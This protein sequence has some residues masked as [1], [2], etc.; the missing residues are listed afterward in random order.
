MSWAQWSD[1]EPITNESWIV[2]QVCMTL[3]CRHRQTVSY[4]ACVECNGIGRLLV[5][6]T[7]KEIQIP[8][9]CPKCPWYLFCIH[10]WVCKKNPKQHPVICCLLCPLQIRVG[11]RVSWWM[12]K[13]RRNK[14]YR[15]TLSCGRCGHFMK[16]CATKP[17]V[18]VRTLI[19][20]PT[21][22]QK[23]QVCSHSISVQVSS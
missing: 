7:T 15:E 21:L 2:L 22:V 4:E 19:F 1:S 20:L 3:S 18:D 10:H 23:G 14:M 17:T 8:W 9:K 16:C 6:A 11:S 12:E 5:Q 13:W